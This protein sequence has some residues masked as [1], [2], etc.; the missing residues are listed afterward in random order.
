MTECIF[1]KI[2]NGEI[3]AKIIHQDEKVI[4]FDDLN[5]QAPIHK[6]IVPRQHIATLNDVNPKDK[7]IMGHMLYIAKQLAD[8]LN[9]AEQGYRTLI[10]CNA[11]GGQVVFHIHLHLL[12]GRPMHWPPG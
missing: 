2:I 7:E 12:G 3:P 5:P 4:A 6:L 8:E 1:C 11:D 9:I 10:N